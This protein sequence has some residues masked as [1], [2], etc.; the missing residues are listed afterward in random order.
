MFRRLISYT[1]ERF[2]V[3]RGE[4]SEAECRYRLAFRMRGGGVFRLLFP[5][6]Q[7]NINH[8]ILSLSIERAD[9]ARRENQ[10]GRP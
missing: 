4:C 6:P 7:L 2:N 3:I 1:A 8:C 9:A 5:L 10:T